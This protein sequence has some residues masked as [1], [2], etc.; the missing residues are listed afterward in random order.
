MSNSALIMM[1]VTQSIVTGFTI[2][3]FV[4]VLKSKAD[5]EDNE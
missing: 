2:Y 3:Y 4:K 5:L 1:I